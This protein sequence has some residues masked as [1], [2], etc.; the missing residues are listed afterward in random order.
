MYVGLGITRKL[1]HYVVEGEDEDA[2]DAVV[3][4]SINVSTSNDHQQ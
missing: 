1:A 4:G 3:A 2:A